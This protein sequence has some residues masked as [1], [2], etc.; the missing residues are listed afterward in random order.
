MFDQ[1]IS[2]TLDSGTVVLNRIRQDQYSS[3]Y[4]ARTTNGVVSMNIRN[5]LFMKKGVSGEL[6]RQYQRHNVELVRT[7]TS[8]AAPVGTTSYK[9]YAVFE[10]PVEGD[11]NIIELVAK[12]VGGFLTTDPNVDKMIA[13]ES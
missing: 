5:T 6:A 3:E 10:G 4:R 2:V 12:A 8:V 1:T 7:V 9:A 13:F 11:I